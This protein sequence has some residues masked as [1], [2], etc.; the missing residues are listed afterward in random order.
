MEL[1]I[2]HH[3]SI[4]VGTDSLASN[5]QLSILEELK[6]LQRF[7]PQLPLSTLLTW[8]TSH[9]AR[10]LQLDNRLGSFTPGKRPGL[11][12]I[13]NL[14]EGKEGPEGCKFTPGSA[15]KRLL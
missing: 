6:T 3:C 11:V 10:A 15:A 12:L 5:H 1:L 14:E 9:G 8:A 13:E 7:L 4:V 2:R